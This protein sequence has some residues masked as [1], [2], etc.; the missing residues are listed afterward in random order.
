MSTKSIPFPTCG[1]LVATTPFAPIFVVDGEH[2]SEFCAHIH[3]KHGFNVATPTSGAVRMAL[4]L[5]LHGGISEEVVSLTHTK[6]RDAG[7]GF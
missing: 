2:Q 1:Y 4:V 7:L 6:V 3:R 5:D